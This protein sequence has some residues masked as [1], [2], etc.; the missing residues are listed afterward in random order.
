MKYIFSIFLALILTA[1]FAQ[2]DTEEVDEVKHYNLIKIGS[3]IQANIEF[4]YYDSYRY[5]GY[6]YDDYNYYTVYES[7]ANTHLFLAYEHIWEFPQSKTAL[8]IE[9]QLGFSF[10]RNL[11]TAYTG[12]QFKFFWANKK[13]WRMGMAMYFGY[14]YANR[15]RKVSV[16]MEGGMYQQR[17]QITT[18]YHQF[19]GDI[20]IIPFQFRVKGAPITIESQF[21]LFG[22][23]I[24]KMRSENYDNGYNSNYF[25]DDVWPAIYTLKFELKIGF[26][27]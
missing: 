10:Y 16:P 6:Y 14:T 11:T 5:D 21:A 22:L 8:A 17:K 18:H 20:S 13:Y 7:G 26:E 3:S 24:T 4:Y 15:D 25:Y 2:S 19:S 1:G 27:F 9:P 23:N 12:A